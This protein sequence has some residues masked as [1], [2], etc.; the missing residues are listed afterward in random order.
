ML[1]VQNI[2]LLSFSASGICRLQELNSL[3]IYCRPLKFVSCLLI[4]VLLYKTIKHFCRHADS[5]AI[6][7]NITVEM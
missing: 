7:N 2:D 5:L 3:V 6:W 1:C 4:N